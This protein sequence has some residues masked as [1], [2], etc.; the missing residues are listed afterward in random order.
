MSKAYNHYTTLCYGQTI[1]KETWVKHFLCGGKLLYIY[2]L[3][4]IIFTVIF[5][6]NATKNKFE[7]VALKAFGE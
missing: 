7:T 4:T 3:G 5:L 2:T 6:T 1:E